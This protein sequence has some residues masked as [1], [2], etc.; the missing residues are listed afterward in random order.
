MSCSRCRKFSD[1]SKLYIQPRQVMKIKYSI[2]PLNDIL[3]TPVYC[4]TA[5]Q[6]AIYTNSSVRD[7]YTMFRESESVA[8]I[9]GFEVTR[10]RTTL[11]SDE[12]GMQQDEYGEYTMKISYLPTIIK[13]RKRGQFRPY[14]PSL[15]QPVFP[16]VGSHCISALLGTLSKKAL[17]I[18]HSSD[19]SISPLPSGQIS[20][21]TIVKPIVEATSDDYYDYLFEEQ[22]P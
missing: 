18:D 6:C 10:I 9:N 2:V 13:V 17:E 5:K 1:K 16:S 20:N 19:W 11:L 22:T 14:A 12:K 15:E 21:T 3:Q 7:I 4:E 8:T